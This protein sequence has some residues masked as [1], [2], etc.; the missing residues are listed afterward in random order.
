MK[1]WSYDL[2]GKRKGKIVEYMY[3][4]LNFVI[5]PS[6]TVFMFIFIITPIPFLEQSTYQCGDE[7]G[8]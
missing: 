2:E 4:Y 5:V 6:C 8:V 1:Y 7:M 3:L